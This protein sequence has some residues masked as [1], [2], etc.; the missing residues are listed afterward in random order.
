MAELQLTV[1]SVPVG[2]QQAEIHV[3]DQAHNLF[4]KDYHLTTWETATDVEIYSDSACSFSGWLWH[5]QNGSKSCAQ[6]ATNY[7]EQES[8][9]PLSD[10]KISLFSNVLWPLD[11]S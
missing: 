3:T 4:M 1:T 2:C 8:P 6:A 10:L 7:K 9:E 5:G 11:Y